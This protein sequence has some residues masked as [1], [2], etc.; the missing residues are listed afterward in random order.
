MFGVEKTVPLLQIFLV[1]DILFA[2]IKREFSLYH[3]LHREI[4]GKT[5]KLVLE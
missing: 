5:T 1:T 3:G 4:N 2:Y